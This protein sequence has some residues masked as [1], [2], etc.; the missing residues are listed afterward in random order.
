MKKKLMM[1]VIFLVVA[2]IC[3][4]EGLDVLIQAAKSQAEIKKQYEEETKNFERV[5]KGIESGAIK[6]GQAKADIYAKYGQPVV[7]IKDMDGKRKDCIYKPESSSFFN[8]IRA[9]LI[10]TEQGILDEVLIEER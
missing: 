3:R 5:K 8:G 2:S 7:S 1:C 4:A 9:T 6:K 10:F